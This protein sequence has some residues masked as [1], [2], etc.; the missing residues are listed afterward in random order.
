MVISNRTGGDLAFRQ[1]SASLL[2]APTV[3][4]E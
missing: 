1:I 4:A 3:H 2:R